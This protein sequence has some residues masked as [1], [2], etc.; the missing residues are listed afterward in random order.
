MALLSGHKFWR[1][2]PR[3]DAALLYPAS[4]EGS[5]DVVFEADPMGPD[6]GDGGNGGGSGGGSGGEATPR[7]VRHPAAAHAV[8]WEA[9]LEAGDLLFV[10]CGCP[11]FVANLDDTVAVSANFVDPASNGDAALEAMADEALSDPA[12]TATRAAVAAAV[13]AAVVG[14][15]AGTV[16]ELEDAP[17]VDVARGHLRSACVFS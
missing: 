5:R 17:Y 7:G 10:P 1:L 4:R 3:G 11:H 6:A 13:V 8:P 15:A 16:P 14:T 9:V 12:A 2:W